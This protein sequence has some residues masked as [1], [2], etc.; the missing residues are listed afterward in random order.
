MHSGGVS[1]GPSRL[2]PL[3]GLLQS[4]NL[5]GGPE[6]PSE[7]DTRARTVLIFFSAHCARK[8]PQVTS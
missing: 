8:S 5:T 1:R 6:A 4:G 3:T 7:F 2:R